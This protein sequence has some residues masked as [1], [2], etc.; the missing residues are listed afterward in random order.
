MLNQL[1]S[2]THGRSPLLHKPQY[3][4]MFSFR[5][6]WAAVMSGYLEVHPELRERYAEIDKAA[7]EFFLTT[8]AD[9]ALVA[10]DQASVQRASELDDR[11][12]RSVVAWLLGIDNNQTPHFVIHPQASPGRINEVV[13][14]LNAHRDEIV[15]CAGGGSK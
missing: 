7:K 11:T 5:A 3:D 9:E 15:E 14:F 2:A 6:L 10:Q 8:I 4:A 13:S 12:L 1:L